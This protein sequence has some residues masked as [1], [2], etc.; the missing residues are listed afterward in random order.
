MSVSHP[1]LIRLFSLYS[2]HVITRSRIPFSFNRGTA[3]LPN[4]N[5]LPT[6]DAFTERFKENLK[7][8]GA[9]STKLGPQ[10]SLF[11]VPIFSVNRVT[12]SKAGPR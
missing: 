7:P 5:I 8:N 10:V 6:A 12:G 1:S 3:L 11:P 2:I 4:D 9:F